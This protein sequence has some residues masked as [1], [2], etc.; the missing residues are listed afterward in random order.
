MG[1]AYAQAVWMLMMML[2]QWM[3]GHEDVI[4]QRKQTHPALP[5]AGTITN[6]SQ[7]SGRS[8]LAEQLRVTIQHFE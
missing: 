4:Y 3:R 2:E 6:P 1:F 8:N 5:T 7:T